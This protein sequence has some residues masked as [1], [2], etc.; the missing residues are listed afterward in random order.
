[1]TS[2]TTQL[3]R[4]PYDMIGGSGPIREIVDRFYDLMESDPA[5][6]ELRALHAPDLDPMRSSLT[7]FLAAWMG[8]PR[9]WFEE[10]P[11]KCLMSAH[12]GVTVT[13]ATARQWADAMRQAIESSSVDSAFGT[14]LAGALGDLAL[15]MG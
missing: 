1:M 7:G 4:T 11:G 2:T 8:G 3:A 6:A 14:K 12:K 10:R 9:D 13:P 5:Y 15:R